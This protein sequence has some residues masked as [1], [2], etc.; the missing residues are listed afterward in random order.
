MSAENLR[1][2]GEI[3]TRIHSVVA[4]LPHERLHTIPDGFRNHIAWNIAH[5][6]ATQQLLHY[7]Q[8][9]IGMHVPE[10]LVATCRRGTSPAD[11]TPGPD[12]D[13][14]LDLLSTMPRRLESDFHAGCFKNY[15]EYTTSA[16][17]KLYT[18][19]DAIAFNNHHEGIHLG[20]VLSMLHLV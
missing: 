19:E 6:V 8:S 18:I 7:A 12:W 1:M 5:L 17:V 3:R 4:E 11:W 2:F 15:H 16:G 9:D 14:V 20:V 13:Q 10:S